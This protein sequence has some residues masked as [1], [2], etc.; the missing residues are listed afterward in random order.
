MALIP[1]P[2]IWGYTSRAQV[3]Q[4]S[5]FSEDNVLLSWEDHRDKALRALRFTEDRPL[6]LLFHHQHPLYIERR[7][8]TFLKVDRHLPC[9][10]SSQI[11]S[12]IST[13]WQALTLVRTLTLLC[14]AH[15]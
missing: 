2:G 15:R 7:D 14:Q 4:G 9:P 3:P 10:A 13:P 1:F 5:E 11:Q 6:G 8:C 12:L